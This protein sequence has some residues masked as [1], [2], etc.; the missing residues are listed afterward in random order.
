MTDTRH[1]ALESIRKAQELLT[2]SPSNFTPSQEGDQV[3][4]EAK[5]LHT[6]HPSTKLAPRQY[7]PF[8]IT[9]VISQTSFQLKLPSQWKVHPVFHASLLTPYK[10][11]TEHGINFPEPPPDLVDGQPE[12]EV[13]QILGA[14]RRHNQLQYLIRWKGF[15]DA[16]DSWEPAI[17]INANQLI[18]DFHREHPSAIRTTT[19][20]KNHNQTEQ[21]PII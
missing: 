7:G 4:L 1:Q 3:W 15:S 16:H 10:E 19:T 13:E 5:N 11:M 18:R 14:R 17:H 2:H 20:L 9:K 8:P 6:S 12:W 21:T